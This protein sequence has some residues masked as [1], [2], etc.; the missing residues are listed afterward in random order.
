MVVFTLPTELEWLIDMV[1]LSIDGQ[2]ELDA[3]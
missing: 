3:L 2:Q 1:D